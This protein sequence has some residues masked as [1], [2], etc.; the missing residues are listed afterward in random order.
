MTG[1]AAVVNSDVYVEETGRLRVWT[2]L[3]ALGTLGIYISDLPN[4]SLEADLMALVFGKPVPL[5]VVQ[6]SATSPNVLE[7]DVAQAWQESDQKA[8]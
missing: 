7:I 1:A 6:R 4:R 8:G 3:K 5:H 2:S